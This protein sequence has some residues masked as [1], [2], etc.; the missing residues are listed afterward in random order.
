M[1]ELTLPTLYAVFQEMLGIWLWP[2][3]L[4]CIFGT[5][6]FFMLVVYE[7]RIATRRLRVSQLIGLLGGVL[8]LFI[9][10]KLSYSS[11]SDVGGAID[12]LLLLM[13]Y[14]GGFVA[15]TI[16]LYTVIGWVKAFSVRG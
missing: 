14:V 1:K 3:I 15:T 8:A 5:L 11:L 6:S 7:K 2:L 12:V 13:T 9:M 4:I 16:I 10:F